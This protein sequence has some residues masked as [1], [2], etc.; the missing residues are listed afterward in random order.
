ML[1]SFVALALA[2]VASAIQITQPTNTTGWTSSGAQMIK[3]DVSGSSVS[4]L[5]PPH[6]PALRSKVS[7]TMVSRQRARPCQPGYLDVGE[8]LNNAILSSCNDICGRLDPRINADSSPSTPTLQTSPSN[9]LTLLTPTPQLRSLLASRLPTAHI[10][11]MQPTS[12][13]V[14][15]GESTLLVIR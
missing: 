9:S 6:I 3:W 8:N 4:P 12:F 1:T 7:L 13:L 15:N 2:A 11:S 10:P 14:V 5:A